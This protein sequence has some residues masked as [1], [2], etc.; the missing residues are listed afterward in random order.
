MAELH[1]ELVAVS[2]L[3]PRH[4]PSRMQQDEVT[5]LPDRLEVLTASA[6]VP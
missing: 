6:V 4:K 3:D 1:R 5:D 2:C